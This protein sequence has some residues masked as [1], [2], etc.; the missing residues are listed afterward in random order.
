MAVF[1]IANLLIVCAT[2]V[3]IVVVT[4]NSASLGTSRRFYE[5]VGAGRCG[6]LGNGR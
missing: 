1:A 5:P 3:V 4:R 6:L 2:C